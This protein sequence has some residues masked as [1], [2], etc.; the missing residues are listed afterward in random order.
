VDNVYV[1][2]GYGTSHRGIQVPREALE[3]PVVTSSARCVLC[4]LM[5]SEVIYSFFA[6]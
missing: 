1:Q 3:C 2:E 6:D 5:F 4:F